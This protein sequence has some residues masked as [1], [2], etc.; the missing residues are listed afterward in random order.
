MK[1]I[2]FKRLVWCLDLPNETKL[3][4]EKIKSKSDIDLEMTFD[5]IM[6]VILSSGTHYKREKKIPINANYETLRIMREMI[7]IWKETKNEE[8]KQL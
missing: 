7:N 2:H 5:G 1:L 4:L 3:E 8:N 6:Y